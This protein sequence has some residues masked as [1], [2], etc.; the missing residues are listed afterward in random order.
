MARSRGMLEALE[1]AA[2]G[3]T[4]APAP[5]AAPSPPQVAPRSDEEP[6]AQRSGSRTGSANPYR[7]GKV[8][9]TGYFDPAVKQSLR[10]IQA[11]F[12]ERKTEQDLLAEALNDL[13]AKHGVPQCAKLSK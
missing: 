3:E 9:V 11:K 13:F 1:K 4:K 12:P 7:P 2:H 5:T 10:M 8:N 6:R